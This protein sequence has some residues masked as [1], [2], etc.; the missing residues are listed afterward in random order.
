M[1]ALY[2][3]V[4]NLLILQ[5][6]LDAQNAKKFVDMAKNLFWVI[7]LSFVKVVMVQ[8]ISAFNNLI[9]FIFALYLFLIHFFYIKN[10]LK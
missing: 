3:K 7:K 5:N 9:Y 1:N 2:A 4:K 8:D 6:M 10:F